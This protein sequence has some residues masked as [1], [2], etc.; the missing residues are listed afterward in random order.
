MNPIA[1]KICVNIL[2]T[3]ETKMARRS[4]LN[5]VG[6]DQYPLPH[7]QLFSKTNDIGFI[8]NLNTNFTR[9]L[10]QLVGY[11]VVGPVRLSVCSSVGFVRNMNSSFRGIL[12]HFWSKVFHIWHNGFLW[13]VYYKDGLAMWT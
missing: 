2:M 13:C 12:S 3:I 4:K 8:S 1:R 11:V 7:E 9:L 10:Y 5:L 6:T